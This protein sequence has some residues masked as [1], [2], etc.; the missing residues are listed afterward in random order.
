MTLA[1]EYQAQKSRLTIASLL[2]THLSL[3]RMMDKYW[4]GLLSAQ[5]ER[6]IESFI[7]PA[8]RIGYKPLEGK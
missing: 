1:E 5:E 6:V 2:A 7:E 3:R 8:E 4:H